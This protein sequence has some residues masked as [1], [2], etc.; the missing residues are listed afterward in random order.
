M[1]R[2]QEQ[3]R[4]RVDEKNKS[5][6]E[7]NRELKRK[8]RGE[9]D[10]YGLKHGEDTA[11]ETKANKQISRPQDEEPNPLTDHAGKPGALRGSP[12]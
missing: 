11:E 7:A 10:D 12:D 1:S 6:E 4:S 5:T 2:Q 8:A 3:A 9:N